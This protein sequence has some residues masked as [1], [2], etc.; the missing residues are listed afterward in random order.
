[1]NTVPGDFVENFK[2][3]L[4]STAQAL[5]DIEFGEPP[6]MKIVSLAIVF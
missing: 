6:A 2:A 5:Q 1:M 4:Q 3:V